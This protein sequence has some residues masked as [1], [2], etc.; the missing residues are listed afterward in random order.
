MT[1]RRRQVLAG[2]ISGVL[3]I[4]AAVVAITLTGTAQPQAAARGDGE[5][6]TAVSLHI[7]KLRRAAPGNQ[8]MA[9]E[10]PGSAQDAALAS[11]IYPGDTLTVAQVD[12]ARAAANR[13]FSRPF[14]TGRG[15]KGTW[16]N[17]GPSEALYPFEELR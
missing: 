4:A 12:N 7:E 1:R 3:V 5:M 13:A 6:P 2:A 17:V 9:S 8:G 14:Q 10:G 11:R 16:V 15:K